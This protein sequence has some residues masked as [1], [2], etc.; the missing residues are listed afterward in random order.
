MNA[1]MR[2]SVIVALVSS[3]IFTSPLEAGEEWGRNPFAFGRASE[4]AA[5]NGTERA[6]PGASPLAVEMVLIHA[7][8]RLAVVNGRTVAVN[9]VVD[10]AVVSGISMDSVSFVKNGK[11]VVRRVGEN[12]DE[13]H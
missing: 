12:Y 1:L 5:G 9:D 8:K 4:T 2:I 7:D 11:T 6:K 10:G 13:A 3:A